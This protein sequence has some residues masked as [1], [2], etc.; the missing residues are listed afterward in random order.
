MYTLYTIHYTDAA[1]HYVYSMHYTV[2]RCR[3]APPTRP[4]A[5]AT[6][7]RT[8]GPRWAGPVKP[9]AIMLVLGLVLVIG[10]L[11]GLTFLCFLLL[12]QVVLADESTRGKLAGLG[13]AVQELGEAEAEPRPEPVSREVMGAWAPDQP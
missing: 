4:P 9:S 11:F 12:M 10:L 5:R 3:C 13:V 2:Y 7:S 8:R 6:T 1:L